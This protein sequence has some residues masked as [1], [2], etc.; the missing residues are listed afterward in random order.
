MI[1]V[2]QTMQMLQVT[3]DYSIQVHQ[4]NLNLLII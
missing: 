2:F 4:N 3:T 1:P